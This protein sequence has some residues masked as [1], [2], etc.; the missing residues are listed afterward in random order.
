MTDEQPKVSKTVA[1]VVVLVSTFVMLGIAEVAVRLQGLAPELGRISVDHYQWSPNPELGYEPIPRATGETASGDPF[2]PSRRFNRL[3]FR[4]RNHTPAPEPGVFRIVVIGD[5]IAEG[6]GVHD[7][8]AIFPAL[9]EK[10]MAEAGHEIEIVNLAVRG[11]NT[12][13]EVAMLVERG[14]AFQPDLVLLQY[15]WND[16]TQMDGG[17]IERLREVEENGEVVDETLMNPLL[18]WSAVYRLLFLGLI[19]DDMQN[20]R[21]Q[22]LKHLTENTVG[23]SF[24]RL[25]EISREQGFPVFVVVF[26]RL[27]KRLVSRKYQGIYRLVMHKSRVDARKVQEY[28]TNHGFMHLNLAL[29]MERCRGDGES[30]AV[31]NFHPNERGHAC[32]ADAITQFLLRQEIPN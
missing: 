15:C 25:A 20:E 17:L 28:S 24:A 22:E 18:T 19:R 6:L 32:A 26:P 13:Q 3:G 14:L 27:E 4:D 5:S 16:V 29:A 12:Q 2:N 31:D 23:S 10:R 8:S 1:L 21:D 9:L 30:L 7:D 11:Y